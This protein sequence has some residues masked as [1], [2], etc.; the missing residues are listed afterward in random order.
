M[1]NK[2]HPRRGTMQYWPRKRALRVVAR[3]RSFPAVAEPRLLGFVAY[4]VGMTS[5]HVKDNRAHSLTKG[6]LISLPVTILECPPVKIVSV[7][8][9][10]DTYNGKKLFKE[11]YVD[12]GKNLKRLMPFLDSKKGSF[13]SITPEMLEGIIDIKAVIYT[14]PGLTSVNKKTPDTLEVAVGGKS[15][16]EKLDYLKSLVGKPISAKDFV[17]AGKFVDVRAVTKGKGF[18]GPVKRFGVD[19]RSH[20]AEKTKRGPG[21]LGSWGTKG[22]FSYRVPLA[23]QMGAQQR[24]EHNKLVVALG[25]DPSK[26]NVKGGYLHYGLVKNPY[27]LIKGSV[28]GAHKRPVVLTAPLRQKKAE[29]YELKMIDLGSNQ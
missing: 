28:F 4:K 24:T 16:Q 10:K 7:R 18:Q 11:I 8:L 19:L 17:S 1:P 23:G 13:D 20:K 2:R 27:M 3:A 21:S 9:Y 22:H 25:D 5:V 15:V 12:S 6:Q 29:A 14:Q 26:V